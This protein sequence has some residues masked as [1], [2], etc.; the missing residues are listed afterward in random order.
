M[1]PHPGIDIDHIRDKAKKD[2]LDLLQGVCKASLTP[3]Y[4]LEATK[5]HRFVGKRI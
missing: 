3:S 2:L 5:L 1:A 4:G